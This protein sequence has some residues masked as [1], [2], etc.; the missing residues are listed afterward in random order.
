MCFVGSVFL[1]LLLVVRMC[2]PLQAV[3]CLVYLCI[4]GTLKGYISA[5]HSSSPSDKVPARDVYL[6]LVVVPSCFDFLII[7]PK[8]TLLMVNVTPQP[9]LPT[10]L[11]HLSV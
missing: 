11:T 3:R 7:A 9:L 6:C 10:Q 8:E 1:E 5:S 4:L 2:F